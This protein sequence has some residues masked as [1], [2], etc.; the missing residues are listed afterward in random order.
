MIALFS[1]FLERVP[2]LS[3]MNFLIVMQETFKTIHNFKNL[4]IIK[5]NPS[6]LPERF[7]FCC[8]VYLYDFLN[9]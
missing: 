9:C 3:N 1:V 7:C 6:V 2:K 5:Q 8:R 4:L